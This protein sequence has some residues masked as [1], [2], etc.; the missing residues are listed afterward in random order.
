MMGT[1]VTVPAVEMMRTVESEP[2]PVIAKGRINDDAHRWRRS[3]VDRA[4]WRRR[5][6]VSRRRSRVR[7]N[8]LSPGVR[9]SG[10]KPE[11][12]DHRY[13]Q[14]NF[15][16]HDRISL[17]LFRPLNPTISSKLLNRSPV[18]TD[19]DTRLQF[20]AAVQES[21]S[22]RAGHGSICQTPR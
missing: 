15:L 22:H 16:Q 3:V 17:L 8:H 20:F 2:R 14:N 12:E 6:I 1:P 9:A 11:C 5:I 4:R 13:Y 10:R 21:C 19:T 18:V 7:F